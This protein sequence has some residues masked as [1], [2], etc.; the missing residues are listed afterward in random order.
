MI[1]HDIARQI[2]ELDEMPSN[3]FSETFP[4]PNQ[5]IQYG[6]DL[7]KN[8]K[9][10]YE[11]FIGKQIHN[12]VYDLTSMFFLFADS[13]ALK[14]SSYNGIFDIHKIITDCQSFLENYALF[15]IRQD[16][17]TELLNVSSILREYIG[18]TLKDIHIDGRIMWIYFEESPSLL[19]GILLP[20]KQSDKPMIYLS[21]E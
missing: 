8:G 14:I 18:K 12:I 6:Y 13:S 5:A 11:E 7:E 15:I 3:I 4:T 10:I 9:K 21:H 20:I 1:N 2:I 17:N 16:K 19:C